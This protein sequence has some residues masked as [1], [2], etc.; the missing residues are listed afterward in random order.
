[1][2]NDLRKI[3]ISDFKNWV[4]QNGYAE[5]N[6]LEYNEKWVGSP[7]FIIFENDLTLLLQRYPDLKKY[8]KGQFLKLIEFEKIAEAHNTFVRNEWKYE[9]TNKRHGDALGY[10][11]S[12]TELFQKDLDMNPV[13]DELLGIFMREKL[14]N[15]MELLNQ[16]QYRRVYCYYFKDMTFREIA[17]LEGVSDKSVRESIEGARKKLKKFL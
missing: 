4:S 11:D 5:F 15:A 6:A 3:N 2:R 8:E 14:K 12:E 10:R 1:M 16:T 17:A 7:A 13:E 9:K